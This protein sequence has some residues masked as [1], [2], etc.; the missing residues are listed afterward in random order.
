MMLG[1]AS[2][3][4]IRSPGKPLSGDKKSKSPNTS[5]LL[6]QLR[7][8]KANIAVEHHFHGGAW[9]ENDVRTAGTQ[10]PGEPAQGARGGANSG[11][12]SEMARRG[13]GHAADSGSGSGSLRYGRRVASFISVALDAA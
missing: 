5:V 2:Q 13:A 4:G 3:F 10:H 1:L 6:P 12:H 8:R 9:P 11:S 7:G